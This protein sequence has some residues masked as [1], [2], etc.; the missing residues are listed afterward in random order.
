MRA[1]GWHAVI[2]GIKQAVETIKFFNCTESP[3]QAFDRGKSRV[4]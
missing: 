4:Y 1:S 3:P 2:N